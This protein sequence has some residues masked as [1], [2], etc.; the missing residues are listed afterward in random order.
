MADTRTI[1]VTFDDGSS[2]TYENV[3]TSVTP[4]QAEARALKDYPNKKV[5]NLDGGKSADVSEKEK[6]GVDLYGMIQRG[7]E[8]VFGKGTPQEAGPEER[9]KKVGETAATAGLVTGG[10]KAAAPYLIGTGE[11]LIA[12]KYRPAQIAGGVLTAAGIGA[13]KIGPKEVIGATAAGGFGQSLEEMA[14]LMGADRPTQ[15]ALGMA[16]GG[17]GTLLAEYPQKVGGAILGFV[18]S[19]FK[20]LAS[21]LTSMF[22]TQAETRAAQLR[23]QAIDKAKNELK[24]G[25][26]A[27]AGK[28]IDTALKEGIAQKQKAK[29]AGALLQ[30]QA[31]IAEAERLRGVQTERKN[32]IQDIERQQVP[33][34]APMDKEKFGSNLQGEIYA[35]Q[36]P[37]INR[38]AAEYEELRN[39]AINYAREKQNIG[40]Y[41]QESEGGQAVKQYWQDK[42]NKGEFSDPQERE[43]QKILGDIYSGGNQGKP[44]DINAID[45]WLRKLADKASYG[46]ETEGVQ[47]LDSSLARQIRKSITD[48]VGENNKKLAGKGLYDWEPAFGEAKGLYSEESQLLKAYDTKSGKKVLEGDLKG[49]DVSKQ[50]FNS[51]KG[52]GELVQQLGGDEAKAAQYAKQHTANELEGK[53][54]EQVNKWL[55]DPKNGWVDNVPGLRKQ[56]TDYSEKQTSLA[57]RAEKATADIERLGKEIPKIEEKSKTWNANVDKWSQD[58]YKQIIGNSKPG[59]AFQNIL[60]SEKTSPAQLKALSTYIAQNPEAKSMVPDAVRNVLSEQS[61]ATIMET[62]DRKIVPVLEGSGLMK[63]SEINDIRIQARKIYEASAK[64][65]RGKPSEKGV[66]AK[67]FINS[68]IAARF[69]Q[70]LTPTP[71]GD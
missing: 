43:I 16:G 58:Q 70:L 1:T 35:T 27:E 23:T 38:R 30:Q 5:K 3:P 54:P 29:E 63:K 19:P 26:T 24:A 18:K 34:E 9:V 36:Q 48:G 21:D 42:I 17:L 59:F 4:D 44:K 65:Y 7:T 60:T 56:V 25:S 57:G 8:A 61:P 47:A 66:K 51:R 32:V 53:T 55:S 52:Y 40:Y 67:D 10:A 37:I 39:K 28:T 41:W 45:S 33:F 11:R 49:Q 62:F 31:D 46:K 68:Q 69:G 20:Y 12:S 15:V 64:D 14:S 2:H 6:P 22:D 50:Y 13:E 71:T